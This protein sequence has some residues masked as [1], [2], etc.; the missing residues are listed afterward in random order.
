MRTL[1]NLT[2]SESA[3]EV[4]RPKPP[5]KARWQR[6]FKPVGAYTDYRPNEL[7]E[8]G[9]LIDREI[10]DRPKRRPVNLDRRRIQTGVTLSDKQLLDLLET[11]AWLNVWSDT[12]V[13]GFTKRRP[14]DFKRRDLVREIRMMSDYWDKTCQEHAEQYAS[15]FMAQELVRE[16]QPNYSRMASLLLEAIASDY[17]HVEGENLA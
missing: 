14:V 6:W 2:L 10:V 8:N 7:R 12:R 9:R 3:Y 1:V 15:E 4:F 16:K 11:W 17:I 13:F 5:L